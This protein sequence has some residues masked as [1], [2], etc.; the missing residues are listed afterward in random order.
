MKY[1]FPR[2]GKLRNWW[3][4]EYIVEKY[5]TDKLEWWKKDYLTEKYDLSLKINDNYKYKLD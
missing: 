2:R 5:L 3:K 4:K 1:T